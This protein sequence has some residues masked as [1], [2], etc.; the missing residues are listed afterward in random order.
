MQGCRHAQDEQD[1]VICTAEPTDVFTA[2]VSVL[3]AKARTGLVSVRSCVWGL[4]L[5]QCSV[6][7]SS[8]RR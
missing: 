5:V 3:Y 1:A 4:W 6:L 2:P 8:T 7:Y